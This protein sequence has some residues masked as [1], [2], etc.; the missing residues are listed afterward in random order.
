MSGQRARFER[1]ERTGWAR[2]SDTYHEGVGRLC[3]GAHLDLLAGARVG[4]GTEV[5]EVGCGTGRL[6]ASAH[7]TGAHVVATDPAA[8][9]AARTGTAVPAVRVLSAALPHLPFA[10]ESFDAAL[11]AFVLNHVADPLAAMAELRRVL[12][13]GGWLSVS[14]WDD[15]ERNRCLGVISEAI[16]EASVHTRGDNPSAFSPINA[17]TGIDTLAELLRETGLRQVSVRRLS[18]THHVPAA[19][20]WRDVL[21]G[22]VRAAA[23]IEE[24]DTAE[25]QAALDAYLRNV[26]S[27]ASDDMLELPASALVAEGT[28]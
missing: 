14:I 18:W 19:K 26:A 27:Y 15:D 4:R 5:L 2:R 3:A 7:A 16:A 6:T 17:Y 20:W 1:F 28:R 24:L 21:G 23:R 9:M 10:G 13:V 12:R 22:T 11:A 25:T 8:G